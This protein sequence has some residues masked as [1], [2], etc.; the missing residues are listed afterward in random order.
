MVGTII[1]GVVLSGCGSAQ[2]STG[3]LTGQAWS[4][5]LGRPVSPTTVYV[6][7]SDYVGEDS[8]ALERVDNLGVDSGEH[9]V[10]SHRVASGD[11][12]RF[13]LNPG[14]YIVY[15]SGVGSARL[16]TVVGDGM[17]RADFSRSCF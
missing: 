14:H 15:D 2:P 16:V 8:A 11:T 7:T 6:F 10:A 1:I 9:V 13:V 4:C 3:V 12:Y 17:A 5:S